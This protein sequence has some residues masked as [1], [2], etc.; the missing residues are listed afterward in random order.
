MKKMLSML[1]LI[2]LCAVVAL[3]GLAEENE[4]IYVLMNIP[5]ADF[6]AHETVNGIGPP[7]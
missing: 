3:T 4:N 6:Y 7:P 2:C 1:L 5:Y